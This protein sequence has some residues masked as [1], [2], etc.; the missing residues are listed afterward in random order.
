MN[1]SPSPKLLFLA[2]VLGALIGLGIA[3]SA[4]SGQSSSAP[5][6]TK[7]GT[8][9]EKICR[10]IWPVCPGDIDLV[11]F[12]AQATDKGASDADASLYLIDVEA[13]TISKWSADPPVADPVVCQKSKRLFYRSGAR[14]MVQDLEVKRDGVHSDGAP[15]AVENVS[16]SAVFGCTSDAGQDDVVWVASL[17]DAG[18]GL[19]PLNVTPRGKIGPVPHDALSE[20]MQDLQA[21]AQLRLLHGIR[22]DGYRIF[23]TND[24]LLAQPKA[25]SD[26]SPL[27]DFELSPHFIGSPAWIGDTRFL[28]ATGW[29]K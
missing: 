29:G 10:K 17:D 5:I 6:S 16:V 28:F 11:K 14:L 21:P 9:L 26:P 22:P 12:V 2:V 19:R 4:E 20:A 8:L 3:T 23:V 24:T 25:A 1:P 13:R 18:N 27:L 7:Q 15:R